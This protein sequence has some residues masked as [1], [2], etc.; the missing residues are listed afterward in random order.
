[1][2]H[3]E[4]V[5]YYESLTY[6]EFFNFSANVVKSYSDHIHIKRTYNLP[7]SREEEIILEFI[8]KQEERNE[9]EK[10]FNV[11]SSESI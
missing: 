4:L 3:Q 11:K 2:D 6:Q 7:L 8:F 10:L 5:E 9:L 1:M